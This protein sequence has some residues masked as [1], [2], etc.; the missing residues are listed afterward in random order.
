MEN[1]EEIMAQLRVV[2]HE[3]ETYDDGYF[4]EAQAARKSGL[5][6]DSYW[7][8]SMDAHHVSGAMFLDALDDILPEPEEKHCKECGQAVPQKE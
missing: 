1:L 5:K 7:A 4:K 2:A 8:G 3:I 6:L